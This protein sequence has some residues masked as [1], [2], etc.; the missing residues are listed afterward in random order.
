[1]PLL[2]RNRCFAQPELAARYLKPS[3]A[4]V[5]V[6]SHEGLCL[7]QRLIF[8]VYTC[9]CIALCAIALAYFMTGD[10]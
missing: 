5:L 10:W 7:V 4:V 8:A 2:V 3:Q 6:V 9:G 1:M